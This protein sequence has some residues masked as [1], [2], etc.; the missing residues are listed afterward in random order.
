MRPNSA[1]EIAWGDD[2]HRSRPPTALHQRVR[3]VSRE[4][5]L[6][7][8]QEAAQV[9]NLEL[10]LALLREENARLRMAQVGRAEIG[11]AIDE[12][13]KLAVH[14]HEDDLGDETWSAIAELLVMREGLDQACSQ[15]SAALASVRQRLARLST[16]TA[17]CLVRC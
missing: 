4:G 5:R 3:A 7:K 9:E 12:F 10:E 6:R 11:V 17:D 15:L 2:D 8:D 14:R 1:I 16:I 13:R